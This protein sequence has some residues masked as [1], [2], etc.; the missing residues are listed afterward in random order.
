MG[1]EPNWIKNKRRD[2]LRKISVLV[3][4]LQDL[5]LQLEKAMKKHGEYNVGK[6]E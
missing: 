1:S 6:G 5:D 2:T 4:K 3:K